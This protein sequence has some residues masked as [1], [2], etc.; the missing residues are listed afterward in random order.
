MKKYLFFVSLVVFCFSF[1]VGCGEPEKPRDYETT[2]DSV[3][4]GDKI[5]ND[6]KATAWT[7]SEIQ[8]NKLF[9]L[10][11]AKV[12]GTADDFKVVRLPDDQSPDGKIV[13]KNVY[14][15]IGYFTYQEKRYRFS[16]M[17][18]LI[19]AD[20]YRVLTLNSQDFDHGLKV[21]NVPLKSDTE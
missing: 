10:D 13:Y 18:S 8:I 15:V 16:M 3:I 6:E 20:N 2:N 9:G 7:Y 5:T 19:D 11:N 4:E 21:I 1:L 12:D 17:Y 14:S